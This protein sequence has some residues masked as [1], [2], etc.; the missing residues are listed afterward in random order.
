MSAVTKIRPDTKGLYEYIYYSHSGVPVECFFDYEPAERGQ[1]GEYLELS[2]AFVGNEDIRDMMSSG[3]I[4]LI[5]TVA[6]AQLQKDRKEDADDYRI[7]QA[8]DN[9]SYDSFASFLG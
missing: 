9:R 8:I 2:Y 1:Y 6:L 4:G 3:V 5:E 7:E